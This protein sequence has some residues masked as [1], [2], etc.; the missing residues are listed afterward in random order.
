MKLNR[1]NVIAVI[2]VRLCISVVPRFSGMERTEEM[3]FV[4]GMAWAG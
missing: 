1:K 2:I 4:A 3:T